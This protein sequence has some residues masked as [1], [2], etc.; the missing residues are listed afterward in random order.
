MTSNPL[1][2]IVTP[3]FNQAKFLAE[4]LGSVELQ[5][6]RPIQQ[7]V[8]DGGSTDG[9][10]ELLRKWGQRDHDAGYS[11]EWISEHDQGHADALN[12]GFDRAQGEIVGWLNS[13]DV[14]FDRRVVSTSVGA[15][16]AHPDV[17][18]VHGEVAMI[19]EDSGLQMIW[20]FPDFNYGRALR[21]YIIPQPTAFFRRCVTD[22]HRLD[23]SL[24]VAID[25]IYWLQIGREHKFL[26]I[27]RVQAGDRDH[28]SRISRLSHEQMMETAKQMCAVYGAGAKESAFLQFQD[29][30]WRILMRLRGLVH[31]LSI[32]GRFRSQDEELA[33]PLWLDS[34]YRLLKRQLSM[35]VRQRAPM[36]PRVG[37]ATG[38]YAAN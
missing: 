20:C 18:V 36:G 7:I 14:Y 31:A 35:R 33:F 1:V 24:H 34:A 4:T 3:S 2:S 22:R 12:K 16:Q 32:L 9:T 15:L 13:D 6:H 26:K 23:P 37:S 5:N 19:S 30:M 25:H 17:D 38:F 8:I 10:V 21:G 11:F 27:P 28:V 29:R